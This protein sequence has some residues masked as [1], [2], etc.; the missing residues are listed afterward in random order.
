[1]RLLF[2]NLAAGLLLAA[3]AWADTQP[4][5]QLDLS[6]LP[7]NE[8]LAGAPFAGFPLSRPSFVHPGEGNEISI[9]ENAEGGGKLL[10]FTKKA[11]SP[12]AAFGF[13]WPPGSIPPTGVTTLQLRL[14]LADESAANG[15][16]TF[17]LLANEGTLAT[18]Q[19]GKTGAL[20]LV[21]P[22]EGTH[23]TITAGRLSQNGFQIL[24][25]RLDHGARE[26]RLLVN[27]QPVGEPAPLEPA[28]SA[29]SL[30]FASATLPE[31]ARCIEFQEITL[32]HQM[33]ES[34]H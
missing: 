5:I 22:E 34:T 23:R 19:I 11:G 31:T 4:I 10:R 17:T 7:E 29:A 27:G 13:T 25:L 21:V 9:A 24:E 28:Q 6:A 16:V 26:L 14:R 30:S 1:M 32:T 20:L 2:A 3:S 8:E 15:N 33:G 18:V 12:R